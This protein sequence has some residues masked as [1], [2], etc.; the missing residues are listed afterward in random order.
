MWVY[1]SPIGDLFIKRL[2]DG[3]Y[4]F[5]YDGVVWES[6]PSPE[7]EADNVYLHIT[8]CADWD[9]LDGQI[10]DVPTGLSEWIPLPG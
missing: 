3:S 8:G 7:T 9:L 2:V 10:K 5:E 1:H 4:G 6:S